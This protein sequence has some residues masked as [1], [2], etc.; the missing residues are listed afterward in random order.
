M[1]HPIYILGLGNMGK[2]VAYALG[3]SH[4]RNLPPTRLIFHRR[5]LLD[6]WIA[7]DRRIRYSTEFDERGRT[8]GYPPA[9]RFGVELPVLGVIDPR[10]EHIKY[11]IVATKAHLTRAALTPI[12][13]RLSRD[14]NI[15]F[16]QN[17]MGVMDEVSHAIFPDP[18][19]RPTYWAGICHA[20][21][22]STSRFSS[23]HAGQGPLILGIAGDSSTSSALRYDQHPLMRL[24]SANGGMLNVQVMEPDAILRHQLAKL[25]VN[26]IINPLSVRCNCK[27]GRV[28]EDPGARRLYDKLLM[29]AGAIVRALLPQG[30]LDEDFS[31]TALD[32]LVKRVARQTAN[33]I[34]SMLQDIQAGRR[35]EVRYINGYLALHGRR[36]GLPHRTHVG[37]VSFIRKIESDPSVS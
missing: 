23:V 19:T 35:T 2:Y 10:Q 15:I 8:I 1:E 20:G 25:V 28:L 37:A 32:A 31:D 36:L 13:H 27:N 24:R 18:A 33:N 3:R 12:K 16:L 11:L 30:A 22:Y 26:S 29:E 6:G 4:A 9:I 34:S 5:G 17:G 14:S 7:A 21:V